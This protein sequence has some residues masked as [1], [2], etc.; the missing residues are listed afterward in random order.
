MLKKTPD[1]SNPF[2]LTLLILL[3]CFCWHRFLQQKG[4]QDIIP[5]QQPF[6]YICLD[7]L[8]DPLLP[9][10]LQLLWHIYIQSVRV[11]YTLTIEVLS[12]SSMV[13]YTLTI[14][15]FQIKSEEIICL[16]FTYNL[17]SDVSIS[18]HP[19][20]QRLMFNE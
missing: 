13:T 11:T 4:L 16:L 9:T 5:E 18:E 14:E 15:V 19:D 2:N 6:S 20:W 10:Y 12:I 3:I 1:Y 7:P 8:N 17:S